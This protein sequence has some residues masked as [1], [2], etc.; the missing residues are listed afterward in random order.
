M[1][2]TLLGPDGRVSARNVA[3]LR[4]AHEQGVE[5]VVATGRRH[6]YAMGPLRGVGLCE[7]N[8]LISSN[9]TVIRSVG[10][11]LLHRS[12]MPA[13]TARW[14]C[15]HAREFRETL[16]LTFDTTAGD[17]TEAPGA[18]VSERGHTLHGTINKWMEANA[19]FFSHVDCIE[20]ALE[21]EPPIQMMLCGTVERMRAAEAMLAA[22]AKVAAP[23][24]ELGPDTEI[25]LHRTEYPERD[26]SIVDILPAG[27][28][29][30]SALERLG[31]MRGVS[32][33][34][35]MGIGDNWNDLAMLQMVGRPVV[36]ANAP[37]DLLELA[38]SHGWTV[39]PSHA[40]DGVAVAVEEALAGVAEV[41][42]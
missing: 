11:E 1:D 32:A 37:A 41:V 29:K 22:H 28:S 40:E 36:M 39:A 12:H 16:V 9:G 15:E 14:L 2:G 23:G 8:A 20:D 25:T 5:V 3:A 6:C 42:R 26:L 33:A 17:G 31:E 18:L 27:I 4:L 35:M 38:R 19:P 10:A 13:G 24:E 34:E 21:G 7:A 30:A